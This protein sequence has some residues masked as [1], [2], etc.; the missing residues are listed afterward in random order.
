ML[1]TS[2]FTSPGGQPSDIL[3]APPCDELDAAALDAGVE[4]H[5]L[6]PKQLHSIREKGYV[7]QTWLNVVK[8]EILFY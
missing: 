7:C 5:P 1:P 8:N 3:I 6:S 2:R 4:P